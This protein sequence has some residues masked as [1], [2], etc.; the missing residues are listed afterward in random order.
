MCL[1]HSYGTIFPASKAQYYEYS[2][3]LVLNG[4]WLKDWHVIAC[5]NPAEDTQLQSVYEGTRGISRPVGSSFSPSAQQSQS[6][7]RV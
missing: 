1:A 7:G 5:R 6:T 3:K 4:V 2:A